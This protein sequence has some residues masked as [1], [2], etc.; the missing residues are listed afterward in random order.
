MFLLSVYRGFRSPAPICQAGG[1][2]ALKKLYHAFTFILL[3]TLPNPSR[4]KKIK[5]GGSMGKRKK[6]GQ[7]NLITVE[8]Y[9]SV[10]PLM[11]KKR[12][13]ILIF[14]QNLWCFLL[15]RNPKR[16]S[17]VEKFFS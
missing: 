17:L 6:I 8:D 15:L 9:L 7:E 4:K 1:V 11:K 10:H 2:Q 14:L 5:E 12:I 16:A 13:G 3:F